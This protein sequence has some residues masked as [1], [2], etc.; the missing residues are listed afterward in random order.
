MIS[1]PTQIPE[2][3][4]GLYTVAFAA[5]S[6]STTVVDG[7]PLSWDPLEAAGGGASEDRFLFIGATPDGDTAVAGQQAPNTMGAGHNAEDISGQCTV[8]IASGDQKLTT[9]RAAAKATITS[10]KQALTADQTLGGA[11]ARAYISSVDR[12]DQTQNENGA[13]VTV[14]FSVTGKAFLR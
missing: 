3:L 11:V 2:F 4:D 5:L 1:S 13:D 12:L 6:A 14:L 7:P 10:L 9:L 8:Y